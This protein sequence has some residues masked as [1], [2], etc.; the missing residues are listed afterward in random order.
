MKTLALA[1]ATTALTA[2]VAAAAGVASYDTNGDRFASFSEVV[3]VNATIDANDFRDLDTNRDRRLSATEITAPG[4]SAVLNRGGVSTGTVLST[5]QIGGGSFVSEAQLAAA[6]PGLTANDFDRIDLNDDNRVSSVE[7]YAS[8]AQTRLGRYENGAQ[9]LVSLDS[10]DVNGDSF[11][12]LSELQVA[13]PKLSS[14]DLIFFDANR[15]NRISFT[16]FYSPDSVQVLGKN[17]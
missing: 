10:V 2:T 15:D 5:V 13:Y 3:A 6:Y 14:N 12:S 1:I 4:A 9:I 8:D 11:A 16:E 7:I 17:K